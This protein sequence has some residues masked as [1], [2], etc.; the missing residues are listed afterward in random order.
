MKQ[1]LSEQQ[2]NTLFLFGLLSFNN[3]AKWLSVTYDALNNLCNSRDSNRPTLF[4][5]HH[6]ILFYL[7]ASLASTF[8]DKISTNT[9][10]LY[11]E[12]DCLESGLKE[13]LLKI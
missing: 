11:L 5:H 4:P 8:I 10:L 3:K 12:H 2:S 6:R 1:Q 13:L 7:S 9:L